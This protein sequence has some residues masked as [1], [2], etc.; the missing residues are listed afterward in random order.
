MTIPHQGGG[1][2]GA[3]SAARPPPRNWRRRERE[4]VAGERSVC[5]EPTDHSEFA[6]DQVPP[7]MVAAVEPV[8]SCTGESGGGCLHAPVAHPAQ[9]W[10]RRWRARIREPGAGRGGGLY[11]FRAAAGVGGV[12]R[13]EGGKNTRE[14]VCEVLCI[15]TV[16]VTVRERRV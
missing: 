16:C 7:D 13:T 15:I 6:V 4:V 9:K 2:V 11:P 5:T 10:A 1:V 8:D 3:S 12:A 14:R